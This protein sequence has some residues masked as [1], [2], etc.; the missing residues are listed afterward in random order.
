MGHTLGVA[1]TLDSVK[2]MRYVSKQAGVAAGSGNGLNINRSFGDP[3]NAASLNDK[4]NS[5]VANS[6]LQYKIGRY[7][8]TENNSNGLFG[9]NNIVTKTQLANEFRPYH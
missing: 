6:A 5:T 1:N 9:A 8:D 3:G 2:S 4:Q 7:L